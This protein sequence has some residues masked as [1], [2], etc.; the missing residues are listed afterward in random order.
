MGMTRAEF[1][2]KLYRS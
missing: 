2:K 1:M